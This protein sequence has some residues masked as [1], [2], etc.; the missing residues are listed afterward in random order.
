MKKRFPALSFVIFS[1]FIIFSSFCQADDW[2]MHGT[3]TWSTGTPAA[4]VRVRLLQGTQEKAVVYT[5]QQGVYGF[6]G[7]PGKPSEYSLEFIFN[8]QLLRQVAPSELQRLQRGEN[9]DI[10]L[11]R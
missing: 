3:V 4:S 8:N 5:N 11:Q 2:L 6:F 7:L 9:F 10:R 1:L